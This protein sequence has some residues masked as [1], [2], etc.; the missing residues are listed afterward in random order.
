MEQYLEFASNNPILIA[1]LVAIMAMIVYTETKRL[2]RKD[3]SL[4]PTQA[5]RRINE[6]G[7]LVLDVR[8][9]S[10]LSSGRIKGAKHIPLK[11]L[12]TRLHELSKY[13]D[14]SVVVYC[15]SGNRSAQACDVLTSNEFEKVVNLQGGV[16]AWQAASLPLSKK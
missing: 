11:E 6:D 10:E 7:S 9:N 16:M 14:K 3:E 15:R 12:K 2:S 5:V 13:K 4:P 1:A 8:E